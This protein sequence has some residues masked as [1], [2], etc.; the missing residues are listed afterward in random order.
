MRERVEKIDPVRGVSY[1]ITRSYE[2]RRGYSGDS[3]GR[4]FRDMLRQ[5]MEEPKP[6]FSS[7]PQ[8][9]SPSEPYALDIKRATH[10]LFYKDSSSSERIGKIL[11]EK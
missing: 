6:L 7:V 10:S 3:K 1:D 9:A 2:E 8:D 11:H 4:S 5:A